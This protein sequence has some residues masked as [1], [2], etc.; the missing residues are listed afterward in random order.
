MASDRK[1]LDNVLEERWAE[2]EELRASGATYS[3]VVTLGEISNCLAY[4]GPH[5]ET[6][7]GIRLQ[8]VALSE[9]ER[10][11][12]RDG[13]DATVRRLHRVLSTGG[14]YEYEEVMLVLT[15]RVD[16]DLFAEGMV[17]LGYGADA[18]MSLEV[19][20]GELRSLMGDP[21]HRALFQSAQRA[22]RRNWG[23]PLSVSWLGHGDAD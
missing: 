15:Y 5:E 20:D 22:A 21:Q 17:A 12:A 6:S 7:R 3:A 19:V 13:A 4:L 14:R 8:E 18:L 16:L 1:T 11:E 9:V 23:L 2:Y 10:R